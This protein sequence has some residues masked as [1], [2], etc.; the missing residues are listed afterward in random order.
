MFS[1]PVDLREAITLFVDEGLSYREIAQVVGCTPKA[2]ETRIY[3]AR[4][5]LKIRLAGLDD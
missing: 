1:L 4:Q 5:I 2:V 3:R